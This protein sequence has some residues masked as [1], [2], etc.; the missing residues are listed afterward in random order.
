AAHVTMLQRSPTYVVARPDRDAIGDA[1]RQRLPK[2]VAHRLIRWKN[3]A[4]GMWFYNLAMR[5]P[6][7]VKA[8]IVNGVR[9][10]LGPDYD[11][12]RHFTPR[13]TP[14]QQRLCMVPNGDL[15]E[16]IKLGSATVVTDEI[17]TF[18]ERGIKMRSGAELE[19][20]LVVTATGFN[21]QVAG[22]IGISV[23]GNP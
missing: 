15:F 13:Y 14:W 17:E 5:R 1:L 12:E 4:F 11:V 18:S 9:T 22:D 19:A 16:A 3:V 2:N 20:D 6:E 8:Y 23:D 7:Q 10:A 21:L